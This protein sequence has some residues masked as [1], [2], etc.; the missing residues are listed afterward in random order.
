M[1]MKAIK[2]FTS[3]Y[4]EKQLKSL[5]KELDEHINNNSTELEIKRTCY[6][7]TSLID[8]A[9]DAKKLNPFLSSTLYNCNRANGLHYIWLIQYGIEK[10]EKRDA[11]I[12]EL[13]EEETKQ[14][15][16]SSGRKMY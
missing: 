12:I 8:R 13:W 15:L 6:Q 5:F 10:S 14:I 7:L 9:T 2:Y 1:T 16:L 3:A 4:Y 11:L